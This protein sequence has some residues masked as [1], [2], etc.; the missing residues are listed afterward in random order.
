MSY[1]FYFYCLLVLVACGSN[2]KSK[3]S[4][5]QKT[6]AQIF[7]DEV[8]YVNSLDFITPHKGSSYNIGEELIVEFDCKK[9]FLLDSSDVFVD[10]N[11]M[12]HLGPGEKRAVLTL[13]K[14]RVGS[15]SVKV[16]G[17]HPQKQQC[18]ITVAIKLKPDKAPVKCTFDIINTF[19]HDKDAYTQGLVYR[20]GYMYE[21]TGQY[22]ESGIRKIDM[23]NQNI[24][25]LLSIDNQYFGEG[26]TI[27][28]DKIYQLT[29]H[30]CKG[31]VYDIK[32]FSLESSFSYSSE[33]WGLT[34][35]NDKLI[36]SDGSHILY[37]IS[38]E[39]FNIL[40]SV[41]VYDNQGPV[42]QL[43][44]LEYVDGLVWANVWLSDRIIAIDP[45]TGI[46]KY[47]IDGSSLLTKAERSALS[48]SDDV[49]NG[50]AWNPES[51]TFY[52]TGKRWPK[53]FEVRIKGLPK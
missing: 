7:N 40:K 53:L 17:Y 3:T 47:E 10:G 2:T 5:E 45:N 49:L 22:G 41:E 30:A 37:H 28:K 38:P 1:W 14:N 16:I 25:S 43:N 21:S 20:E 12:A 6:K 33:G 4:V 23:S 36:M 26:I 52:L 32:S 46:V 29:W 9:R 31:F 50:I 44:E 18:I 13:P 39:G 34:T 51:K 19:K 8:K 48:D 35:C 27:W 15:S 24:L 42:K 11:K